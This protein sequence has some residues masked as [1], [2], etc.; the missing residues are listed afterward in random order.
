VI[1]QTLSLWHVPPGSSSIAN[2]ANERI[3]VSAEADENPNVN[4]VLSRVLLQFGAR[5][6][7]DLT[8]TWLS[9]LIIKRMP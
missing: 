5:K 9:K 7:L 3:V 1:K 2:L 8:L 4:Q 6:I